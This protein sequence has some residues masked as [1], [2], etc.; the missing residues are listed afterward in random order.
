MDT[1]PKT[2]RV[3]LINTHPYGFRTGEPAEVVSV[4]MV[5]PSEDHDWRLCY[6]LVFEDGTRD[7]TAVEDN[8]NFE[9]LIGVELP[10]LEK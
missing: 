9:F 10:L 3:F 1:F 4:K 2:E 8:K 5:K 7:F 6:E